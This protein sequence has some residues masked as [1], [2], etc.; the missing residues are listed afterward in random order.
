[1]SYNI[2]ESV[3]SVGVSKKYVNKVIEE[4]F[5]ALKKKNKDVSVHFIG[6]KKMKSINSD[7]RGVN[8]TTDVVA[9]AMQEGKLFDKTDLGDIFISV[10]QVKKQAKEQS[11]SYKEEFTRVLIHGIL[12]LN[13]YDHITKKQETKM[14]G[15]QERLL[16]KVMS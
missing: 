2:Y 8:K 13:G 10:N 14:F 6:D 12:H 5:K 7:Y 4:T 16:K 9:F 1:M 11:I 15:L 3:R